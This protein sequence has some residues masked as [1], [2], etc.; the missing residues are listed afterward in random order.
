MSRYRDIMSV[1]SSTANIPISG[2]ILHRSTDAYI[3]FNSTDRLD[4]I[5]N[6]IYGDPKFWW[7]I[8]M[9]NNYQMEFDIDYGEILRVP[10]PLVNAIKDVKSGS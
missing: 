5:S 6:R 2:K 4:L 9:A 3:Q 7:L 8:L 10:L 1:N